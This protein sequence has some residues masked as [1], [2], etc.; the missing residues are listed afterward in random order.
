MPGLLAGIRAGTDQRQLQGAVETGAS[1][2]QA[3]LHRQVELGRIHV[4]H[5]AGG[6]CDRQG[7]TGL[8]GGAVPVDDR[9]RCPQG[10]AAGG[11]QAVELQ[12]Q[13][14]HLAQDGTTARQGGATDAGISGQPLA[15][16]RRRPRRQ[17]FGVE[18]QP[19]IR[20]GELKSETFRAESGF[21]IGK[22]DDHLIHGHAGAIAEQHG[23]VGTALNRH[24]SLHL[25]D[26]PEAHGHGSPQPGFAV[27]E[28][29]RLTAAGRCHGAIEV[30]SPAIDA[31]T[32]ALGTE[33]DA[34]HAADGNGATGRERIALRGSPR[35]CRGDGFHHH[36]APPSA[37]RGLQAADLEIGG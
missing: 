34:S 2:G 21:T 15:R 24:R 22:A 27:L 7:L 29:D 33:A 1:Q 30:V 23:L 16:R 8:I 36:R 31:N 3:S 18:N 32:D 13:R 10:T 20:V 25:E 28:I 11:E 6:G 19:H 35:P 4:Q 17:P 37:D 26:V 12:T 9:S 14:A 5:H